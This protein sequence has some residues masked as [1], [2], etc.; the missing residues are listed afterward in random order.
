MPVIKLGIRQQLGT[1]ANP[2]KFLPRT[3]SILG[4]RAQGKKDRSGDPVR[5]LQSWPHTN[6]GGVSNS[7]TNGGEDKPKLATV[8]KR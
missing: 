5:L 8:L 7:R 6:K 1:L 2:G 4:T 3:K